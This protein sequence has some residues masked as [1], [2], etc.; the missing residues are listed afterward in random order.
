MLT[1]ISDLSKEGL[2]A[3]RLAALQFTPLAWLFIEEK[4]KGPPIPG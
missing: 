1:D 4:N 2:H 3:K